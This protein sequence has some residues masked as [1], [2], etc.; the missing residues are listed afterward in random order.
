MPQGSILGPT[1]FLIYINNL[2]GCFLD[3]DCLLYADNLKIFIE[4]DNVHH[5]DNKQKLQNDLNCLSQWSELWKLPIN[6]NKCA[7]LEFCNVKPQEL[8]T[9]TTD[10]SNSSSYNLQDTDL[11]HKTS[12][13][14]LGILFENTLNFKRHINNI[15][16]KASRNAYM[17]RKCFKF[18]SLKCKKLLYTSMVRLHLEFASIVWSPISKMRN[19]DIEKV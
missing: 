16:F 17:I 5:L 11:T 8:S 1:L 3:A 15:I 9:N 10:L 12:I 7:V 4:V 14:D 18:S 2:P 19:N 13:L 6:V